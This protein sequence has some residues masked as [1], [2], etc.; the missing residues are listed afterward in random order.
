MSN[1]IKMSHNQLEQMRKPM[2]K[3]KENDH[4]IMN[5]REEIL[6]KIDLKPMGNSK[7]L[8]QPIRSLHEKGNKL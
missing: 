7:E 1:E 8:R 6:G 5:K 2:R 4:K 3:D